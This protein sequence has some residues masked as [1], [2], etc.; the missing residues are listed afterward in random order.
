LP[1]ERLIK[2]TPARMCPTLPGNTAQRILLLINAQ[3]D[4]SMQ[5]RSG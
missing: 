4:P 5:D 3:G 1:S 2:K